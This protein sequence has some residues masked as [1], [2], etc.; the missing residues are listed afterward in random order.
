M[1]NKGYFSVGEAVAGFSAAPGLPSCQYRQLATTAPSQ[2]RFRHI[3]ALN[4]LCQNH[5]NVKSHEMWTC[6]PVV[7]GT[8][9]G[10]FL[11][12]FLVLSAPPFHCSICA[13]RHMVQDRLQDTAWVSQWWSLASWTKS[14]KRKWLKLPPVSSSLKKILN[15][16]SGTLNT[17]FLG[18][19][20]HR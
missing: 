5:L 11:P 1:W 6:F 12:R 17:E 16:L 9:Q 14:V 7:P 13:G 3:S 20:F 18:Y 19:K 8:S 4:C 10:C 2:V 15:E